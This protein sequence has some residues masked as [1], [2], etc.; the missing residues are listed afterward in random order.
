MWWSNSCLHF[1]FQY[2]KTLFK[3]AKNVQI[4]F[5]KA[6]VDNSLTVLCKVGIVCAA[7]SSMVND[8]C[9]LIIRRL[10]TQIIVNPLRIRNIPWLRPR[11]PTIMVNTHW[12]HWNHMLDTRPLYPRGTEIL[13]TYFEFYVCQQQAQ[14]FLRVLVGRSL[15]FRFNS[16]GE[17]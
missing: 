14:Q 10:A 16:I 9:Y 6:D 3:T 1:W 17:S 2:K 12:H 11:R 13:Q 15:D 8:L 5:M 7:S 4:S